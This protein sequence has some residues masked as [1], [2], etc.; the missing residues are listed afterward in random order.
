M[1]RAS[2]AAAFTGEATAE[3]QVLI[4]PAT[5]AGL[6]GDIVH[7]RKHDNNKQHMR[8]SNVLAL[9]IEYVHTRTFIVES[10]A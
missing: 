6:S 5:A 3:L 9:N 4:A 1:C 8:W 10:E 2:A 7:S